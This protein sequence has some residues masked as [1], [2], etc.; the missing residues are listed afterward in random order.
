MK[1]MIELDPKS[2]EDL[3]NYDT[4]RKGLHPVCGPCPLNPCG[5]QAKIIYKL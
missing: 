4:E 1:D 2:R 5:L 3:L